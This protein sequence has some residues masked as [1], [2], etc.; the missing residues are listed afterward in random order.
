MWITITL[1]VLFGLALA[2]GGWGRSHS[3]YWRWSPTAIIV[4][5]AVALFFSGHLSLHG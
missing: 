3:A 5:V 2:V 4:L 1:I